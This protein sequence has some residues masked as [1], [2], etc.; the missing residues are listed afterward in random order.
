ML[1]SSCSDYKLSDILQK[2]KLLYFDG[3]LFICYLFIWGG[4]KFLFFC[5]FCWFFKAHIEPFWSVNISVCRLEKTAG[6]LQFF[7]PRTG[8]LT[9]WEASILKWKQCNSKLS[10]I[11]TRQVKFHSTHFGKQLISECDCIYRIKLSLRIEVR[12]INAYF[13]YYFYFITC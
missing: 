11:D 7:L 2:A 1:W 13:Q 6:K 4:E 9:W 5:P 10:L 3:F 8:R 12:P